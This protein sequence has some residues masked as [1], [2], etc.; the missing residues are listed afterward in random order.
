MKKICLT[1]I[2]LYMMV[3][4]AIGQYE[5]KD[6]TYYVAQPLQVDQVHLVSSYYSQNGDHSAIT[7]GIGTERVVDLSN[8]LDVTLV[9]TDA[10][11]RKNTLVA[12]LGFDVHSSASSAHVSTTGASKK[13]GARIYPSLDWTVDDAKKGTSMGVGLYLSEEYN[14]SSFGV[15]TSYSKKTHNNGEFSGKLVGYFDRVKMIYPSEF[16]QVAT[17]TSASGGG[18]SKA[19]IPSKPRVTGTAELSFSQVIN[20]RMQGII[21]V[22]GVAQGGYLGLPFHRVYFKD[23]SPAI[24]NL[25]SERF[26]LPIGVRLNYFL[27]GRIIL[28]SYYRYYA[29]SW[30]IRANTASL[31]VPYKITPFVSLS[32]F[33]RYYQQTAAKYFAPFEV[34]TEADQYYTS[35]YAYSAFTSHFFGMNL[36]LAPP[37]GISGN[38]RSL[39]LRYGHYIQSTN[40][41]SDVISID[42]E[43]K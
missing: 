18:E 16:V 12:G 33:Y 15:N 2:G 31:E 34:H 19:K 9:G 8:G 42:L 5:D 30:G 22:D 40:L 25:P 17:I 20:Q 3:L 10:K 11:D 26:K 14:Y 35:N 7:G 43:F 24:E 36:R 38:L 23:G 6:T 4:H 37:K 13:G 21:I 28:R 27:G 29:D 39:E 32:P 41:H 1:L